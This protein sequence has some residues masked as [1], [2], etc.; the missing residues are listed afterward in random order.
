VAI[1]VVGFAS[2]GHA[3]TC[4]NDAT[5]GRV[6]A[7]DWISDLAKVGSLFSTT[8][9]TVTARDPGE[10]PAKLV[11]APAPGLVFPTF[12]AIAP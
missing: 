8:P 10:L 6:T 9:I 12:W 1:L 3:E 11:N 4:L 2:V 7:G 5:L